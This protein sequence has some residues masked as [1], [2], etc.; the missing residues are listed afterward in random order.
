MVLALVALTLL[1][2]CCPSAS[3]STLTVDARTDAFFRWLKENGA[4]LT[5]HVDLHVF[6]SGVRGVISADHVLVPRACATLDMFTFCAKHAGVADQL[7][8]LTDS[9]HGKLVSLFARLHPAGPH[10][11]RARAEPVGPESTPAAADVNPDGHGHRHR[12]APA[13][14]GARGR[15]GDGRGLR[16]TRAGYRPPFDA[17]ED[18]RACVVLVPVHTGPVR[19]ACAHA[20]A[21]CVNVVVCQ[22]WCVNKLSRLPACLPARPP[23]RLPTPA[24]L[25]GRR[26]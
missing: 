7:P 12:P 24:D 26:G 21:T 5:E 13:P 25:A 2:N 14:A 10:P 17:G 8:R 20:R 3:A 16:H 9:Q 15:G 22:R 23:A 6:P 18:T 11:A 4:E 19:R 1:L